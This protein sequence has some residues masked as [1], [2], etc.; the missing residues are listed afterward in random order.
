[1]YLEY[2]SQVERGSY[3]DNLKGNHHDELGIGESQ[4]E[5]AQKG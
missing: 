3:D 5:S 2:I 1:M 4:G